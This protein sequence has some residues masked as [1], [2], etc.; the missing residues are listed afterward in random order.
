M[1][2]AHLPDYDFPFGLRI[3]PLTLSL[4]C[5]CLVGPASQLLLFPSMLLELATSLPLLTD[6]DHP[7]RPARHLEMLPP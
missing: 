1:P 5:S 3:L 4:P 2:L 6:Y 7:H